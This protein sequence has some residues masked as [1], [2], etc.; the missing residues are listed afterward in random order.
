M[1]ILEIKNLSNEDEEHID[2]PY[3]NSDIT[4]L[5]IKSEV[6]NEESFGDSNSS[7]ESDGET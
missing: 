1:N 7:S 5:F 3:L 2:T 4:N 6:N